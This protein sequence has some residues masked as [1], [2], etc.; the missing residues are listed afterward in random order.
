MSTSPTTVALHQDI[1]VLVFDE[2]IIEAQKASQRRAFPWDP[3]DRKE[4]THDPF[5]AEFQQWPREVRGLS[6]A[7]YI[8]TIPHAYKIVDLTRASRLSD[9]DDMDRLAGGR[10]KISIQTHT[11]RMLVP[12][13]EAL[14]AAAVA[15]VRCCKSL[16]IL[17]WKI[18]DFKRVNRA[19]ISLKSQRFL[20]AFMRNSRYY[21]SATIRRYT[22][23]P[24]LVARRAEST[25]HPEGL[26]IKGWQGNLDNPRLDHDSRLEGFMPMVKLFIDRPFLWWPDSGEEFLA[27]WDFSLLEHLRCPSN[28][29]DPI[30]LL[31]FLT[32]EVLRCLRTSDLSFYSI[33]DDKKATSFRHQNILSID[34]IAPAG[35]TLARL[36]LTDDDRKARTPLSIQDFE[37]LRNRCPKLQEITIDLPLFQY[38]NIIG[39]LE[40]VIFKAEEALQVL[41]TFRTLQL[42]TEFSLGSHNTDMDLETSTDLDN[43][44]AEAIMRKLYATKAGRPFQRIAI[45]LILPENQRHGPK[46][47]RPNGCRADITFSTFQGSLAP[48]SMATAYTSSGL[49]MDQA[50]SEKIR[51]THHG[52]SSLWKKKK[53]SEKESMKSLFTNCI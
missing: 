46:R 1:W 5:T 52:P 6:R 49:N 37:S 27:I 30:S 33:D 36:H 19:N 20:H 26:R 44:D 12:V 50:A 4:E 18:D 16:F 23:M 34:T 8:A 43:D 42:A 53:T 35:G 10:I 21:D 45:C 47:L 28:G 24:G 40:N 14:L 15:L 39:T 29:S 13:E 11:Q 22:T 25:G 2:E 3:Q 7:F 17:V 32:N 48:K 38:P 51:Y 9:L 41:A 31:K